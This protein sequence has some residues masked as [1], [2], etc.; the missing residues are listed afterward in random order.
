[1]CRVR[2]EA[3]LELFLALPLSVCGRTALL[4]GG[5]PD[6]GDMLHWK[7]PSDIE[8]ADHD[9]DPMKSQQEKV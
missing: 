1:M 9:D 4:G 8:N 5:R 2:A 3:A 6:H 7:I